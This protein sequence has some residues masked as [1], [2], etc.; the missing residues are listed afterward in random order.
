MTS[1]SS[2][3]TSSCLQI[4]KVVYGKCSKISNTYLFLFSNKMLVFKAGIHKLLVRVA[5]REEPD[6]TAFSE[7]V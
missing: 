1:S 3:S 4:K 7:A 6:Q 2:S 5:N